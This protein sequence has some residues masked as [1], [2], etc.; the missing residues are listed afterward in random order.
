MSSMEGT[1]LGVQLELLQLHKRGGSR[2]LRGT[3][4]YRSLREGT[5]PDTEIYLSIHMSNTMLAILQRRETDLIAISIS[6]PK[7]QHPIRH[8]KQEAD[9]TERLQS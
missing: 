5:M 1:E 4:T 3:Y 8:T 9:K 2:P 7:I 6:R